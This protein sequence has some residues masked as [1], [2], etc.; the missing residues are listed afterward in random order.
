MTFQLIQ[1]THHTI[2]DQLLL[3]EELLRNTSGN[4]ILINSGTSPAIVLGISGK[5]SELI[6]LDQLPP[7]IPLIRRFSG[8]GTVIVDE[9][10][11]F[12]TFICNKS[13]H[14][15]PPYPEPILRWTAAQLKPTIP[16]LELRDNDFVIG[17]RKC[18][19]NALYIK[20]DRW[21]VHTSLLWDYNPSRMQL[22]KHPPKTPPY[23]AGRSHDEFLCKLSDIFPSKQ[24]W[25][26]TL[27]QSFPAI[28]IATPS[29]LP[30]SAY[31]TTIL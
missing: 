12:I 9:E 19:G 26:D 3:E 11:L 15:F 16:H 2:H 13:L 29:L 24:A 31:S 21:L 4:Y 23:R 8:G 1:L 18:G 28:P 30:S 25:L 6:H 10:T 17:S 22:L 14:A 5:A 7:S 27:I 20:K